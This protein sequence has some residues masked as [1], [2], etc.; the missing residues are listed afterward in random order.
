MG[1]IHSFA[2]ESKGQ[3]VTASRYCVLRTN[4]QLNDRSRALIFEAGEIGNAG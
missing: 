4:I 2:S 1:F 3:V